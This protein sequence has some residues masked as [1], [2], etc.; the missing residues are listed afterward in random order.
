MKP[1]ILV[2]HSLPDVK[3]N[4]PA[5]E[6]QLSV[7]GKVKAEKLAEYLGSNKPEFIVSSDEP[8][9]IQTAEII[10]GQLGLVNQIVDNLHEHDRRDSPFYSKEEFQLLIQEFF[11]R[12]NALIFG[13]E[14]AAQAL[15][16][17]HAAVDHVLTR[18]EDKVVIIVAHGTVISLLAESITGCDGY[19][20]WQKLGLPSFVIIDVQ[21]RQ[22]LET[23]NLS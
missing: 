1:L 3:M 21:F 22:L 6:W 2:K 13:R 7:T 14:T 15:E 18:F 19:G 17:F 9:A 8:K 12:P 23:I 5:R 16:R 10:A 11:A 4:I 20:L